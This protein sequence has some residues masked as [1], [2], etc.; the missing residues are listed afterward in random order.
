M[1]LQDV[2][3]AIYANHIYEYIVID[4]NFKAVEWSEAATIYCNEELLKSKQGDIFELVP[5]LFGMEEELRELLYEHTVPILI[6]YVFKEPDNYVNIRVHCGKAEETLI[7]LFENVTQMAKKDQSLVQEVNEK[8]LLLDELAEKNKQLRALNEHM[9]ELVER[10]TKKNIEKQKML[11]I[12][13]RHAQMGEM[14]GMITHQWKQPLNSINTLCILLEVSQRKKKLSLEALL[15][16]VG[17]IK[18]Q[19]DY[20]NKTV[21]D[22]QHFFNPSKMRYD[23]NVKEAIET[24]VGLIRS[25]YEVNGIKI[26]LTG[27]EDVVVNGYANEYNQAILSIIKNA[28]D[29]FLDNPKENMKISIDISK[30]E[31]N[32]S[33]VRIK[34]N[35]GGIDEEII[36]KIFDVYVSTKKD[37]SGLGLN[38]AKTIIESN[39]EGELKV[40]NVDGGAEFVVIV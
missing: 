20:M 31:N 26:E 16:Y 29:A 37:G 22:F 10:E 11:E 21:S 15:R 2:F 5:E 6:Q 1:H 4:K 39:M 13:S 17:E 34:D 28:K 38:I 23:F 24:I 14:I 33:V 32:R 35:A 9:Q 18:K 12:N 7:V 40:H 27:D 19:V 25:E 36:D 8:A 3:C 30:D